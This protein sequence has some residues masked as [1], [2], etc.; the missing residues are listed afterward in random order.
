MSSQE[1]DLDRLQS[2]VGLKVVAFNHLLSSS[3]LY[4]QMSISYC[5]RSLM[6]GHTVCRRGECGM[7]F[8]PSCKTIAR[9]DQK[10]CVDVALFERRKAHFHSCDPKHKP[11]TNEITERSQA[12]LFMMNSA[13]KIS[14]HRLRGRTTSS[15][16]GGR[17]F[18][19]TD[20]QARISFWQ[21][22]RH[23]K[24]MRNKPP[25]SI[26]IGSSP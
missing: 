6:G 13:A 15:A 9:V 18:L 20:R 24:T 10:T 22:E 17:K 21:L 2:T 26:W 25:A 4:C 11:A 12:I 16:L 1:C 3:T 19:D 23:A 14:V 5:F 8:F 7:A